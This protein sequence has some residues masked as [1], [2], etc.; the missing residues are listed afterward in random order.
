MLRSFIG[1]YE[2]KVDGKGRMSIPASF[3]RVLEADDPD[4]TEGQPA[5]LYINYG[6]HLTQNL[7]VYTIG[8]M[9]RIVASIRE[10]EPGSDLRI[11]LNRTYLGQ[12]EEIVA[13]KDGRI[14]LPIKHRDKLGITEGVVNY[15]GLDDYFEIWAAD[16]YTG[17]VTDTTEALLARLA[18]GADPLSLIGRQKKLEGGA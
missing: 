7:R 8:A 6:A 15:M 16:A 4:W 12:S 13:D 5:R 11:L 9:Q 10:L 18:G 14:V 3:R 17:N 2:Q 1:E